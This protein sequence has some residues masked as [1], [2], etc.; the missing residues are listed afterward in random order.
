MAGE[1]AV[2]QVVRE[3]VLPAEGR[4]VR[5]GATAAP[6]TRGGDASIFRQ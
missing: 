1:T 5:G 2:S 6:L 3:G 4:A